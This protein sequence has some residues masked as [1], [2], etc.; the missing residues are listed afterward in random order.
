VAVAVLAVAIIGLLTVF[1]D[2]AGDGPIDAAA[3]GD[4]ADH[5]IFGFP[6]TNDDGTTGTLGDFQGQPLV[7]NFFASWCP[8]CR[9]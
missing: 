9:A 4:P 5:A 1:A 8:P 2:D 7:V 3:S 6:F